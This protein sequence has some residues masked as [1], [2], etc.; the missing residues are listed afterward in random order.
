MAVF[1]QENL[2][3]QSHHLKLKNERSKVD[4]LQ[5][6]EVCKRKVY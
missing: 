1:A 2:I 5:I 3:D 6:G 4:F